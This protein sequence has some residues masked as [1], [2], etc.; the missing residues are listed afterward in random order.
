MG[1]STSK[2]KESSRTEQIRRVQKNK[3]LVG[4]KPMKKSKY[5]K[6]LDKYS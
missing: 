1:K 4:S 5:S 2:K 6:L 3:G